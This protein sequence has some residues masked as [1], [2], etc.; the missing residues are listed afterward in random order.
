MP[1]R[2]PRCVLV[3]CVCP[4]VCSQV[5][6]RQIRFSC[7]RQLVDLSPIG[8]FSPVAPRC[9]LSTGPRCLRRSTRSIGESASRAPGRPPPPPRRV[10]PP[11]VNRDPPPTPAQLLRHH[12]VFLSP[13][14][15]SVSR[16][17]LFSFAPLLRAASKRT[18]SPHPIAFCLFCL[19]VALFALLCV[20]PLRLFSVMRPLR[21]LDS[22][23]TPSPTASG[24]A[25]G[26]PPGAR[27]QRR[28]S[29]PPAWRP[30]GGD[31]TAGCALCWAGRRSLL[32]SFHVS[33]GRPR[34]SFAQIRLVTSHPQLSPTRPDPLRH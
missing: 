6:G 4:R 30:G 19:F 18:R 22:F 26:A 21:P 5:N 16:R 27:A 11:S 7:A 29:L 9:P 1:C 33:P 32:V 8:V 31:R 2:V 15:M 10:F 13:R 34:R 14:L 25:S 20:A 24:A 12:R 23:V 28:L 3:P 17:Q